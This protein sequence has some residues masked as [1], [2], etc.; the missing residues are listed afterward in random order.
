MHL[1]TELVDFL[2]IQELVRIKTAVYKTKTTA[3][4]VTKPRVLAFFPLIQQK[5]SKK[6]SFRKIKLSFE[7]NNLENSLKNSSFC[8]DF[9]KP[10]KR[11]QTNKNLLKNRNATLTLPESYKIQKRSAYRLGNIL[12]NLFCTYS[13]LQLPAIDA[14]H[15]SR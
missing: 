8:P 6:K 2:E 15:D 5:G 7:K 4:N 13:A 1:R 3:E 10:E 11:S 14:F 12:F 9:E